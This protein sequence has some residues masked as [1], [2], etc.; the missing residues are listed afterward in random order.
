MKENRDMQAAVRAALA[1]GRPRCRRF[2]LL[3]A[4]FFSALA[5]SLPL[6]AQGPYRQEQLPGFSS[7]DVGSH[8]APEFAD[9]D[10]DGDLDA[11]LG[12][13]DGRLYYFANT[14]TSA[15]PSFVERRGA[16]NPFGAVDLFAFSMPSLADLDGD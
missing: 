10:A 1:L 13:I 8:S 11:I 6:A 4:V 16:A 14:G 15:A 3:G 5:G 12:E 9:L 7:F 2:G